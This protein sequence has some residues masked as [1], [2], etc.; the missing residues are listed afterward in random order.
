M[1]SDDDEAGED[2]WFSSLRLIALQT[3]PN[4]FKYP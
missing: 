3:I 2:D 1:T 4:A